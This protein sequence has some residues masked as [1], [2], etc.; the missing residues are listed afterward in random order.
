M[1]LQVPAHVGQSLAELDNVFDRRRRTEVTH[2]VKAR[3]TETSG[4]QPAQLRFAYRQRHQRD[5]HVG[6]PADREDILGHRV[7]ETVRVGL[8]HHAPLDAEQRMQCEKFLFRR[9]GGRE[10]SPWRE[11][12]ACQRAEYVNMGVACPGRKLQPRTGRRRMVRG[13]RRRHCGIHNLPKVRFCP[14]SGCL[15]AE[16]NAFLSGCRQRTKAVTCGPAP[17]PFRAHST[18]RERLRCASKTARAPPSSDAAL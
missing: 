10:A 17:L 1:Q 6:T 4:V 7:V 11:R 12:E 8:Y 15:D 18:D 2:E 13:W 14:M 5:T 16:T 9:F 3:S